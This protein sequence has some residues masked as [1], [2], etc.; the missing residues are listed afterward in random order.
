VN[1]NVSERDSEILFLKQ[2][3]KSLNE[4]VNAFKLEQA[5]AKKNTKVK[6]K[7]I[8]K[9][10]VKSENLETL[11]KNWKDQCGT[12]KKERTSLEKVLKKKEKAQKNAHDKHLK[13]TSSHSTS[14]GQH[15]EQLHHRLASHHNQVSTH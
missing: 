4:K 14:L 12:I 1:R 3:I 9:L 8:Y 15:L 5:K 2:S 6:D 13:L 7:E 11:V 10:Q